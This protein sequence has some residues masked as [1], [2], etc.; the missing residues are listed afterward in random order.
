[1]E[2]GAAPAAGIVAEAFVE[3][4]VQ[5]AHLRVETETNLRKCSFD[6][7]GEVACEA[8]SLWLFS[9]KEFMALGVFRNSSLK[10]LGADDGLGGGSDV[11]RV[12]ADTV[13]VDLSSCVGEL[14][15]YFISFNAAVGA[16]VLHLDSGKPA[17]LEKAAPDVAKDAVS[18][19]EGA[20]L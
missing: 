9:T 10:A 2:R 17:Q 4:A 12:D 3:D 19:A 16:D 7:A 6:E 1:M 18:G 11:S 5:T 8:Q 13:L 14:V 15:D 20:S